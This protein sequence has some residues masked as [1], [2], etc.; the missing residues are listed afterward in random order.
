MPRNPIHSDRSI[1]PRIEAMIDRGMSVVE[2]AKALRI[3]PQF[4]ERVALSVTCDVKQ[5]DQNPPD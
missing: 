5:K 2:I 4:V 3:T 1:R